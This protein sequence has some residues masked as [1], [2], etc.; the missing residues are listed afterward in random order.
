M[1][2]IRD[3]VHQNISVSPRSSNENV[4]AN[5]F[6]ENVVQNQGCGAESG[7][8]FEPFPILLASISSFVGDPYLPEKSAHQ[9]TF[10]LPI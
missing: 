4:Y 10:T 5:A 1:G 3:F 8:I 6:P 7:V 2:C 9:N